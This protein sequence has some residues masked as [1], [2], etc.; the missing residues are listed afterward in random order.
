MTSSLVALSISISSNISSINNLV[1][2]H[3]FLLQ[4]FLIIWY[5]LLSTIMQLL[6]HL[7]HIY[8]LHS[9]IAAILSCSRNFIWPLL[10]S[11][12]HSLLSHP[13]NWCPSTVALS[14]KEVSDII[15]VSS[16]ASFLGSTSST[17]SSAT[18]YFF[19]T[20]HYSILLLNFWHLLFSSASEAEVS[21]RSKRCDSLVTRH[22]LYL[23][24]NHCC[25]RWSQVAFGYD[26]L[27]CN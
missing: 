25:Y 23:E 4:R 20:R 22:I 11:P 9:I 5:V 3:M 27:H 1:F 15:S 17:S 13:Y 10:V 6:L 12:I 7:I 16:L 19:T 18:S 21:A 14:E 26:S 24:R 8:S 2:L